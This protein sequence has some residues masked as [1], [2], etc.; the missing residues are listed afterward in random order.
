MNRSRK[1]TIQTAGRKYDVVVF[2]YV[3]GEMTN[4]FVD[5]KGLG[6]RQAARR[7]E[8]V[9][10]LLDAAFVQGYAQGCHDHAVRFPRSA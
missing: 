10:E 7:K 8:A 6:P 2:F 1:V 4:V 9:E 5:S 3:N